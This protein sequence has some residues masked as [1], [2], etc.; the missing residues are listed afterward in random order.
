MIGKSKMQEEVGDLFVTESAITVKLLPSKKSATRPIKWFED[1][2]V[3]N[4]KV[5]IKDLK[6]L[7]GKLQGARR[8][9]RGLTVMTDRGAGYDLKKTG[10][11]KIVEAAGME[12]LR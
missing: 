8:V 11:T 12:V 7:V 2:K 3:T 10:L 1:G 5:A 9:V 4:V 6:V